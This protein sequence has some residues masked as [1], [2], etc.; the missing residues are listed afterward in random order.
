MG[1][2]SINNLAKKNPS[3]W[4]ISDF[5]DIG[6]VIAG[7][8]LVQFLYKYPNID[9]IGNYNEYAE[10]VEMFFKWLLKRRIT[11]FVVFDGALDMDNKDIGIV[12]GKT[13]H[14]IDKPEEGTPV[15][16]ILTFIN[17]LDKLRINYLKSDFEA[18]RDVQK[19]GNDLKCPVLSSNSDFFVFDVQFGYIPFDSLPFKSILTGVNKSSVEIKIYFIQN[20]LKKF[21]YLTDKMALLATALGNDTFV[22]DSKALQFAY[23]TDNFRLPECMAITSD[24]FETPCERN[25]PFF[26]TTRKVL[27][28]ISRCKDVER[29]K[30]QLQYY[31]KEDKNEEER[32]FRSLEVYTETGKYTSY[33]LYDLIH[34]SDARRFCRS[35]F[36][37]GI[38]KWIIEHHRRGKIPNFAMNTLIH[39]KNIFTCQLEGTHETSS[40][41]CSLSIREVIYALLVGTETNITEYDRQKGSLCKFSRKGVISTTGVLKDLHVPDMSSAVKIKI[42]STAL[43]CSVPSSKTSGQLD[44]TR[45]FLMITAYWARVAEPSINNNFIKSVLICYILFSARHKEFQPGTKIIRRLENLHSEATEFADGHIKSY[46]DFI[47]NIIYTFAQ[48]QSCILY[49]THLNSLLQCPLENVN[50]TIVF[51]GSFL[52]KM[53]YILNEK[54]EDII[55]KHLY[56][57]NVFV[58]FNQMLYFLQE[59]VCI[60]NSA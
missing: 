39:K 19:L 20:L 54:N 16:A 4:K 1:I 60:N 6:L 59:N 9:T 2:P 42:L 21:P 5:Q 31:C 58:W 52:H 55:A 13:K 51:N 30:R 22:K 7:N 10:K 47:L 56:G 24:V 40:H 38:R 45:L 49:T 26:I 32:L 44:Q 28:W 35:S 14:R 43:C 12:L 3:F 37:F 48:F 57:C 23:H 41:D 15:L 8:C 33:N 17:I 11:P 18:D 34:R 53:Y 36:P 27:Y 29:G 25:E 50:P 46:R